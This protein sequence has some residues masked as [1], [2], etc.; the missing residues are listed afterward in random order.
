LHLRQLADVVGEMGQ[1]VPSTYA[2]IGGTDLFV[3]PA[4]ATATVL[5]VGAVR[6][7]PML[8]LPTDSPLLPDAYSDWLI[9]EAAVRVAI[10][11]NN[12]ERIAHLREE[13]VVAKRA[14]IDNARR[15]AGLPAIRR[16]RPSIWPYSG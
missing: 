6:T 9:S 7:E 1:G 11:V 3:S 15:T 14:V 16:T 4:S 12:A 10:S 8:V 13:A 5:T 2:P